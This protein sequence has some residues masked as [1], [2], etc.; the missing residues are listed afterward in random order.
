MVRFVVESEGEVFERLVDDIC[1]VCCDVVI[2]WVF[3]F[4]FFSGL[5]PIVYRVF[6]LLLQIQMVFLKKGRK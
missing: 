3:F 2:V 4:S 6:C 5:A 1:G